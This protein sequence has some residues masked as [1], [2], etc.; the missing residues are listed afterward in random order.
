[1]RLSE[2]SGA[3]L[4]WAS[5]EASGDA[6]LG[7]GATLAGG[8]VTEAGG[9]LVLAAAGAVVV[10]DPPEQAAMITAAIDTAVARRKI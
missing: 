2:P 10:P 1:L 7:K 3:A 8:T 9:P 4:P 6:R 5:A